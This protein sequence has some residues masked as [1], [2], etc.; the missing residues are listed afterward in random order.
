MSKKYKQ[1]SSFLY[2][3]NIKQF[4]IILYFKYSTN[5]EICE[6][7]KYDRE[8]MFQ[9]YMLQEVLLHTFVFAD[10]IKSW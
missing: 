4:S 6:K 3:F 10:R 7:I 1:T 5:L 2:A 8:N 9:K